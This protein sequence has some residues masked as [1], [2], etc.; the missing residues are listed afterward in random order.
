MEK[1]YFR[2]YFVAIA[3]L[4]LA[5]WAMVYKTGVATTDEAGIV[6][7]LP[8]DAGEWHGVELRFCVDRT[9]GAAYTADQLA[10]MSTCPKCGGPLESMN[11]AEKAMLPDDTQ[12]T[13]KHY[14]HS[15]GIALSAAIVL[16]GDDRSSIH[17]PEVCQRAAGNSFEHRLI[18][19]PL[20]G[21][22]PLEVMVLEM[23]RKYARPD[24]TI[25]VYPSFYAYWFVGKNRETASHGQRMWWMAY[26]RVVNGVSHRWAYIA[27][28]GYR[29]P[30]S[31]AHIHII[32]DFV[33]NAYP[34]LLKP[35]FTGSEE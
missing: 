15:G 16:S 33:R 2:A 28:F 23:T 34:L 27:L 22:A 1:A 29:N 12:I 19:V 26:D 17:R 24:G 13:K 30:D 31:D 7:H 25:V 9:C 11:W 5:A 21:R 10:D 35:D 6:M 18:A 4:V 14:T 20:E 8:E 3:V 32:S